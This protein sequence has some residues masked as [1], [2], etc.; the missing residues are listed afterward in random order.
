MAIGFGG[1][2]YEMTLFSEGFQRRFVINPCSLGFF[3]SLALTIMTI[4]FPFLLTFSAS[5]GS[6]WSKVSVGV[7]HPD[8]NFNG[9]FYLETLFVDSEDQFS[10]SMAY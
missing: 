8:V 10:R 7:E 1:L 5:T 3:F 9:D 4:L 6:F 2:A